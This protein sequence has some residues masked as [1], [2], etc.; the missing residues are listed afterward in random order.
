M[1]TNTSLDVAAFL[2]TVEGWVW[3]PPLLL[4][5]LGTHLFLTFR[6]GFIQKYLPKMIRLSLVTD[7]EGEGE[8]HHFGALSTAMASTVGTGNIIGVAGAIVLGGPGA[9]F[10]MWITGI[11]GIAT[12]YGEAVLSIKYRQK[13]TDGS[14]RGGPMFVLEHG[15]NMKWL[16]VLFAAFTAVAAF[17]IGNGVQSNALAEMML[18]NFGWEKWISGVLIATLVALVILG[19]IKSIA[20]VCQALVPAMVIFYLVACLIILGLNAG[21]I[22][23]ALGLI[24]EQAFTGQALAGGFLGSLLITVQAGIARGLFSN[25]AGLGSAPMVAAAA[26]TTNPV[27][28][29][30]VSAS[31][32]FWDTVVICLITGLTFVVTGAYLGVESDSKDLV[33]QNAFGA[34]TF[35]P[36]FLTLALA[37]FVFSTILG[38]SYYGEVAMD[39][40][41]GPKS[42]I[43]YR[44]VWVA[45]VVLGAVSTIDAVWSFAGIMNGFMAVPNLI[46]LL[47]LHNVIASETKKYIHEPE[48]VAPETSKTHPNLKES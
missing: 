8:V 20:R 16:G 24:L 29:A 33:A 7:P 42:I 13:E 32:T 4:L 25:E 5:L 34:L 45:V 10:W 26:Q 35:G 46:A 19:G 11:F 17:G 9:I 40:L 23:A 2:S 48:K 31:A 37:S 18:N 15:M 44:V 28:Q 38:W 1:E 22:P 30:L 39:Y 41:F 14:V 27:R 12:K 47:A 43:P 21:E 6:L 36:T 3:G